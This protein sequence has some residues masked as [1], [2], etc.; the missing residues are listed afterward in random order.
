MPICSERVPR[1]IVDL[2]TK[3]CG[4][5]DRT[6]HSQSIFL[7]TLRRIADRA[8]QL[9]L[10]IS[11]TADEIDHLLRHRIVKH[12]V[13]REIATLRVLF[14]RRK[15]NGARPSSIDINIIR[16]KGRHFELKTV[17]HHDNDAE[18]G[19][20]RVGARKNLLHRFRLGIGGDI[21]VFRSLA[22][23]N[24]AHTA[25]GEIRDVTT[26]AQL[27]D[28]FTRR[29]FHRGNTSVGRFHLHHSL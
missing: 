13:D 10:K 22:A 25:S 11:A 2:V 12:T 6:Q 15:A 1:L 7:E 26:L 19:A 5:A 16:T 9:R 23:N 27:G 18:M 20:D 28:D 14:R 8:H 17:F 24:V 3:H 4:E 21:E 29:L